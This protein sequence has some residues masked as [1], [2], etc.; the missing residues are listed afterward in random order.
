MDIGDSKW[1]VA[2]ALLIESFNEATGL[3]LPIDEEYDTMGGLVLHQL[4]AIPEDGTQPEV[5]AFGLHFKV[6]EIA[7]R[8]IEWVEVDRQL[9]STEEEN[10]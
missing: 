3:E 4:G 9:P 10:V 8:R 6:L 1:R 7:D 2:G 5:E